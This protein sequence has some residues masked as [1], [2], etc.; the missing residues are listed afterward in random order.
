MISCWHFWS[1][2][3]RKEKL[4]LVEMTLCFTKQ[5][6]SLIVVLYTV[7]LILYTLC[8]TPVCFT[9]VQ[10]SVL[11]HLN[12]P[13]W[14]VCVCCIKHTQLSVITKLCQ[15]TCRYKDNPA[16]VCQW[17]LEIKHHLT[18]WGQDDRGSVL[19]FSHRYI[20]T[21]ISYH[22]L[23]NVST[24]TLLDDFRC[25]SS[26]C[27][28]SL[29]LCTVNLFLS[30]SQHSVVPSAFCEA[31]IGCIIVLGN[32][33]VVVLEETVHRVLTAHTCVFVGL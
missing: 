4:T 27:S 5:T 24:L 15:L 31:L 21:Y 22:S 13:L 10:T 14:C 6:V 25:S 1:K 3:V 32:P 16:F 26:T 28:R 17:D 9:P 2:N 20:V 23:C 33:P 29:I 7:L 19:V 12:S 18:C 8:F 30:T 11:V